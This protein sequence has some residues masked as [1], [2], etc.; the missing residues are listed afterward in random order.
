MCTALIQVRDIWGNY[1]TCRCLPDSES[2]ALLA[3]NECI[4]R[5]GLRKEKANVSI[6]CPGASDTRTNGLTEIQFTSHFPTQNSL[7]AS[8][9]VSN[10][11][12]DP[13]FG[14]FHVLLGVVLT[15]PSLKGQTLS[16]GKDKP[17]VI[18]SKLGWKIAGKANSGGQNFLHVNHIQL[19]SD[20]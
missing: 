17:F 18:H 16:L 7:H 15:L 20:H 9:Y 2:Q 14:P 11:I 5:L 6:S 10:K 19:V 1:Q 3:T 13:A 12:L 4:K 8:V